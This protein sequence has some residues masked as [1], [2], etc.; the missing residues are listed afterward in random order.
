MITVDP[1]DISTSAFHSYMLGA[2]A[3]R[4]IAFAS[5]VDEEGIPNLAPFSFYNAYSSNPP[6]LVFSANRRVRDN[7]TKDTYAN[8]KATG[9][10]VINAVSYNIVRQ[11]AL[12]SVEYG[13][14]I[15]E[16]E[17]AGLTPLASLKVKPYRVAEA[18]AQFECKVKDVI[19]L[20]QEGGAGN[21]FI[22]EI[23]L[24]HIHKAVLDE[25]GHI[26]V[27]K[28][29][30][31]GRLGGSKYV[32]ASG[33]A[34]FD[35]P[36]PPERIVIGMDQLP[37]QIKYSKV[38]T[39]NHLAM[40][41]NVTAIPVKDITFQTGAMADTEALHLSIRQLLEEGKVDEAW[42]TILHAL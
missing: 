6:I 25:K 18:P 22:C 16:F 12:A 26:D 37:Q 29:D 39:G 4:P 41:A 33:A 27:H 24:A 13:A 5:T 38:L 10:V 31:C 30:L 7:S 21:L 36:Q 1:A 2:V 11:M 28:I 42:Q 32:R 40:L 34:I 14:S 17:K 35:L 20:G 19:E 23:V 15:N 9:D 8:I 3:P